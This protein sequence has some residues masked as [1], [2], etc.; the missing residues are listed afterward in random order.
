MNYN[1][2]GF[3]NILIVIVV[4]IVLGIV[5]YYVAIRNTG[6]LVNTQSQNNDEVPQNQKGVV[7]YFSIEPSIKAQGGW[8]MYRNGAK[9]VLKGKNLKS[10]EVRYFSTGTSITESSLGGRM[11]KIS[12]SQDGDT[13]EVKLPT[14]ILA[15]DFWVEAEDLEGG[16]IKS[17]G[18]GNVGYQE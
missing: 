14:F 4:V 15:T 3:A 6:S 8:I 10:A 12:E 17:L 5:G 18:L 7:L 1:Q 13:W 16:K 2:K 11:I 9:A